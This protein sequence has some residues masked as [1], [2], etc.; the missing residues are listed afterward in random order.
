MEI[1]PGRQ[2]LIN[3]PV[4][5]DQERDE[6]ETLYN[7]IYSRTMLT[8]NLTNGVYLRT[9]EGTQDTNFIKD[10]YIKVFGQELQ[11]SCS[12][13]FHKMIVNL[14]HEIIRYKKYKTK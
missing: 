8:S 6:I 13:K 5:T 11:C 14:R 12:D 9:P 4:L 1:K 2:T 3:K 10:I 7:Q